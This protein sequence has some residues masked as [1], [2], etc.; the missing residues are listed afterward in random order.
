MPPTRLDDLVCE[1]PD[2]TISPG[3]IPIPPYTTVLRSSLCGQAISISSQTMPPHG[4]IAT[5]P[6]FPEYCDGTEIGIPGR[7]L[8]HTWD[9]P[10]MGIF[11]EKIFHS[12]YI[13]I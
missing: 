9:P 6:G 12:A 4:A 2:R 10:G 7:P 8:V 1:Q 5:V 13:Y 11:N 3:T